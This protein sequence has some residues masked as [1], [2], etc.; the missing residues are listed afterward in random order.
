MQQQQDPLTQIQQRELAIKEAEAQHKMKMDEL[1]LQL[2]A[3]KL[4]SDNK[5]A[6]AKI[7]AQIASELD[8]RQRKDKIAG[9]KL[10]LDI[11]K[12]LDKGGT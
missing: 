11:A 8:D 4:Q 9:T 3:A 10:G 1:K 6:G 12:E 2:E 5:I 7:G